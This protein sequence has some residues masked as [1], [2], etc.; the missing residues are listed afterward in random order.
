MQDLVVMRR[1]G[2]AAQ[3]RHDGERE[4]LAS[5]AAAQGRLGPAVVRAGPSSR[6][7]SRGSYWLAHPLVSAAGQTRSP[8][9]TRARTPIAASPTSGPRRGARCPSRARCRSGVASATWS[10]TWFRGAWCNRFDAFDPEAEAV[11]QARQLAQSAGLGAIAYHVGVLDSLGFAERTFGRPLCPPISPPISKKL[12]EF[13]AT[14][15]AIAEARRVPPSPR[16]CR[17]RSV[18]MDRHADRGRQ[19]ALGRFAP[20]APNDAK[21]REA[22]CWPGRP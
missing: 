21:G 7:R 17:A 9:A 18:P 6:L 13:F 14:A 2:A 22:R 19:C 1:R 15:A 3:A 4:R 10:G 5:A 12:E 16:V 8:R 11:A 20:S